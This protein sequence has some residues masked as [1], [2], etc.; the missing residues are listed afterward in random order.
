MKFCLNVN[1]YDKCKISKTHN[2]VKRLKAHEHGVL[3]SSIR[4]VPGL[5]PSRGGTLGTNR[6]SRLVE[7]ELFD[8]LRITVIG[9]G[10][11]L[12]VSEDS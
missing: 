11:E 7:A 8:K 2:N 9:F 12:R 5:L 6:W 4:L 10:G 3:L 1:E